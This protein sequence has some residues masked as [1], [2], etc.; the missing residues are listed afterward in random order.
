MFLSSSC[1][2][3]TKQYLS[4]VYSFCIIYYYCY[5]VKCDVNRLLSMQITNILKYFNT[6]IHLTFLILKGTLT[7]YERKNEAKKAYEVEWMRK[8]QV[9]RRKKL[10]TIR[11]IYHLDVFK[12]PKILDICS[13]V[14]FIWM[15]IFNTPEFPLICY[16]RFYSSMPK[17]TLIFIF[18]AEKRKPSKTDDLCIFSWNKIF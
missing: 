13:N 18:S 9:H 8:R 5:D 12:I 6:F 4:F 7:G 15:C 14:G 11:K 2:S 10:K 3:T 1:S 17:V 16:T